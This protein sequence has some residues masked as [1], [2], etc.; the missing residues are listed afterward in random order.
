M[1]SISE[2]ACASSSGSALTSTAAF[3]MS[4]AACRSSARA[5]RALMHFLRIAAVSMLSTG[6][7]RSGRSLYGFDGSNGMGT[8][9]PSLSTGRRATSIRST[10]RPYMSKIGVYFDIYALSRRRDRQV[11]RD[12]S[13][14]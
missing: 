5:T 8:K 10:G 14:T 2:L 4:S 3:G 12:M 6:G 9:P 1:F 11:D 7:G 13:K